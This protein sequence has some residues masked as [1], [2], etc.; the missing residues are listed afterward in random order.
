MKCPKCGTVCKKKDK[1]CESC[2]NELNKKTVQERTSTPKSKKFLSRKNIICFASIG[3]IICSIIVYFVCFS[4]KTYKFEELYDIKVEGVNGYGTLVVEK[5]KDLPSTSIDKLV[6]T[7][8]ISPTKDSN[9]KNGDMVTITLSYDE[10]TSKKEKIKITKQ[11]KHEVKDL[12]EG[13]VLDLFKDLELT[14]SNKSPF[15]KVTV[16]N[17]N[18]DIE[19]YNINYNVSSLDTNKSSESK[20]FYTNGEK[21]SITA[22]YDKEKLNKDG[23][24]VQTENKEFEVPNHDMYFT[25]S[26]ELTKEMLDPLLKKMSEK[27][28]EYETPGAGYKNCANYKN[29]KSEKKMVVSKKAKLENLYFGY[30]ENTQSGEKFD[31]INTTLIGV[32]KVFYKYKDGTSE[33]SNYFYVH[34]DNFYLTKDGTLSDFEANPDIEW[35]MHNNKGD[36]DTYLTW[37]ANDEYDDYKFDFEEID[38]DD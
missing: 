3:L 27:I 17:K 9:L 15:L 22:T 21:I 34:V 13:K 7:V 12:E 14:F 37:V 28:N 1:F 36:D 16:A 24:I 32:Y 19:K 25:N 31:S 35:S 20:D 11:Y 4:Y 26:K 10:A 30:K 29:C 5:K 18:I 2:G 8:V 6:E 23:Y 33:F 38:I